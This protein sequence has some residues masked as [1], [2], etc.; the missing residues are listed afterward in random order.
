MLATPGEVNAT[1]VSQV[2]GN[3]E[4]GFPKS[5]VCP[6]IIPVDGA[7]FTLPFCDNPPGIYIISL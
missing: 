2:K 6:Q 7:G 4:D 1:R 5:A 3:P